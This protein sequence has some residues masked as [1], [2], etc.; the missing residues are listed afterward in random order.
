MKLAPSRA[1]CAAGVVALLLFAGASA[2][3]ALMNWGDVAD[4]AGNV[5]FRQVTED[6]DEATTLFAP[7]ATGPTA[8][9][10]TLRFSPV[11]FQS[12]SQAN[13]ADAIDSTIRTTIQARPGASIDTVTI[14]EFGD[15]SLGGLLGG[16]ANASVGAAFFWRI[17]GINGA[18]AML[19][20]ETATLAVSGGGFFSRPTGDGS[21]RPWT[22]SVLL[23]LASYLSV[24]QI[25][26]LVTRV[27]LTFDNTLQT[28]ADQVSTA[29]IKKKGV[30]IVVDGEIPEPA[31]AGLI[32]AAL[33]SIAA[34]RYRLG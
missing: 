19:P 33:A 24:N 21:A 22:G 32:A 26:G 13:S 5:V 8:V 6:N 29:F 28:A 14:F 25:S 15:Y 31:A 23:D 34:M 4:P 10:D 30:E 7:I 11:G 1:L 2:P 18:A 16:Q 9:G 20:L 17:T 27:E 12:Q 3:A